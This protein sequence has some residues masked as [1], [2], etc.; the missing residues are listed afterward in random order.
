MAERAGASLKR[1]FPE[2]EDDDDD[3]GRPPQERKVRFPKGKKARR[4]N[5][6]ATGGNEDENAGAFGRW[7]NPEHAAKER[8]KRRSLKRENDLFKDQVGAGGVEDIARAEVHYEV[9]DSFEDDGIK[10]EPFNLKQEREEGYFDT[11]GNYV[12]YVAKD[13]IKD[14]WLDNIEVDPTLAEKKYEKTT[15]EEE[16]EDL[17]SEDIGKM[18]RRI[19]NALRPGETVLQ[20]LKRLKGTSGSKKEKMPEEAKRTFDQLT[21]DAMKLMES[22]EYNVYYEKQETFER[23]AEGYERL[24]HAREGTSRNSTNGSYEFASGEDMFSDG[25]VAE[26]P[27]HSE[28]ATGALQASEITANVSSVDGD[29][30]FDMFGDDDEDTT[31]K[32]PEASESLQNQHPEKADEGCETD[33]KFDESSG[34]YYSSSLGYYYDP[35]SGLYCCA[36]SGKWYSFNEQT[37]AYDEIRADGSHQTAEPL[38]FR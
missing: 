31:T 19:A 9:N 22:G 36:A 25:V 37:G 14:A 24:V 2:E 3:G 29:A 16:Y 18:K 30:A 17:S 35:V 34:Y 8:A 32:P 11:E 13:E 12:E 23:E 38:V 28:F 27:S 10:I 4:G 21:D 26:N 5:E 33:Y 7:M 20:A 1:S 15:Q 6:V